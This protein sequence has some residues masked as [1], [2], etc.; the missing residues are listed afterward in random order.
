MTLPTSQHTVRFVAAVL[1]TCGALT[2]DLA[3]AQD[4]SLQSIGGA[5]A[6]PAQT[7]IYTAREF[8]TMDPKKPRAEAIAVRDGKF[9]AVG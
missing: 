7:V 1:A 2:A 4:F 6:P 8:I 9:V 5:L 3:A